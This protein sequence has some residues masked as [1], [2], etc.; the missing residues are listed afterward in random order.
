MVAKRGGT[1]VG[2]KA[3]AQE[4]EA[5]L[6]RLSCGLSDEEMQRVLVWALMTLHG[7]DLDQLF[8]RLGPETGGTLKSIL[9][10]RGKATKGRSPV[11]GTAKVRQEWERAWH[12]WW[13]CVEVSSDEQGEYVLQEHHWKPPYLDTYA[14]TGDLEPIAERMGK[15]LGRVIGEDLDPDFSMAAAFV[16]TAA[17]TGSGLPE[18]MDQAEGDS[19]EFQEQATRCLLEWEWLAAQR[20]GLGAYDFVRNVRRTE[21]SD[22]RVCLDGG[23][24]AEFID[25]LRGANQQAILRGIN[26]HR[27]A[28]EWSEVLS[29]VYSHW[30][31]IYQ[32]LCR[33]WDSQKYLEMCRQGISTNWRLALPVVDELLKKKNVKGA[34]EVAEEAVRSL[35]HLR[36]GETWDPRT[37]LL[38]SPLSRVGDEGDRDLARLLRRWLKAAEALERLDLVCALRIQVVT[39]TRR[40]DWDAAVEEFRKIPSSLDDLRRRLFSEWAAWVRNECLDLDPEAGDPQE[41]TW[42]EALLIAVHEGGRRR[43]ASFRQS[44]EKLLGEAER[45]ENRLRAAHDS[46][47]MLTLDLDRQGRLR[48]EYPSLYRVLAVWDVGDR[49]MRKRRRIWL[50]YCK[51]PALLPKVIAF[52]KRNA[53]KLVPDPVQSN[54][55]RCAAW[56]AAVNELDVPAYRRIVAKWQTAHRRRR[57]LWKAISK[58]RLVPDQH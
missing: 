47:A 49:A 32:H 2:R 18:W 27:R 30:L 42:I 6:E 10:E 19:I 22:S 28:K 55:E 16:Q 7:K 44:V 33:R 34:A 46:L 20:D 25:S 11:A 21:L 37:S 56:L 54:Y 1:T 36:G 38:V 50:E 43:T 4:E 9:A 48:R 17:E 39:C 5:L 51:G 23:V 14:L 13:Q 45:T 29:K 3:A 57:N 52:W 53:A 35:P 58:R 40:T 12:D 15:L 8:A 41:S 24:V 26:E 31:R